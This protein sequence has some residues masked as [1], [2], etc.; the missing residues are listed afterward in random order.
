[1]NTTWPLTAGVCI[2]PENLH[3]DTPGG[4]CGSGRIHTVW[5]KYSNAQ[6]H[7]IRSRPGG[8]LLVERTRVISHARAE[9]PSPPWL[10]IRSPLLSGALQYQPRSVRRP[11]GRPRLS[12]QFRLRRS[13]SSE[14]AGRFAHIVKR[15]RIFRPVSP[16]RKSRPHSIRRPVG[17]QTADRPAPTIRPVTEK[18]SSLLARAG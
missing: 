13:A 3:I 10:P 5:S 11:G 16:R 14:A 2:P 9:A 8:S 6:N 7:V 15:A 18:V 4:T 12:F 17:I 1:V